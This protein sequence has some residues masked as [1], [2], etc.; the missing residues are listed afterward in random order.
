MTG[1]VAD[2]D[3]GVP[4]FVEDM[5]EADYH[6]HDSISKSGLDLIARSPAHDFYAPPRK[7]TRA[8]EVGSAI[9]CALFEPGRFERDY[10][11]LRD[12]TDRR[13]SAYREACEHHPKSHVLT[14]TEADKVAGMQA[15][16][17]AQPEAR[18]QLKQPGKRELSAF[19]HDPETGVL[20]RCRYDLLTDAAAALDLKK[21][22][23]ARPDAFAKSIYNYRYHV[24][25]AIYSDIHYW[26]TGEPLQAYA[27]LAVEEDPPHACA[28]YV[29]DDEAMELGRRL[30][31]R[32][33]NT[34][35]HCRRMEEWPTYDIGVQ[36]LS[37][38]AWAITKTENELE[39]A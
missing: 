21:T 26:I 17:Y 18:H 32:D 3:R 20:V 6:G 12:V 31:R 13:A 10:V 39:A 38:P 11:L 19:A 5:P 29:L 16:V 30:Y 7:T 28:I 23:D 24:Q 33:L 37:L 2:K 35:A 8:M 1:S 14:G 27:F 9:H 36:I 15:A 22:Y 25:A 4:C 34:Y